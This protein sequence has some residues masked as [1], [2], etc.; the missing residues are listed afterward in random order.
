MYLYTRTTPYGLTLVEILVALSISVVI[1]AAIYQTFRVQQQSYVVQSE[2]AEMQQSL[3]AGMHLL[4]REIRSAAYDPTG[5]AGAS[6]VTA[7]APPHDSF[8]VNYSPPPPD[9]ITMLAFTI[10][11]NGDR[12]INSNNDNNGDG[13]IDIN[14]TE[15]IAYRYNSAARRLERFRVTD[16]G[17][18]IVLAN[19]DAVNFVFVDRTGAVTTNPTQFQFVEISL[20]IRSDR[21]THDYTTTTAYRTKRNFNLCASCTGDHY[22]RRLLS[23]TVE[24]RNAGLG[25]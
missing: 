16:G 1:T 20:L 17:W 9:G 13:I 6:F 2:A 24:I 18:D 22:H 19:V 3:R 14:D 25:K 4:T 7:F 23:T 21:P 10:D 15:E 5:E 11:E 12:A 8:T